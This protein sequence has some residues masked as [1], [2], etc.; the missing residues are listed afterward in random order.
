[1]CPH[2][3]F[4]QIKLGCTDQS[5]TVVFPWLMKAESIP[6]GN[7]YTS[8]CV[9]Q[10]ALLEIGREPCVCANF[11]L[12]VY[13]YL[14][15]RSR[16]EEKGGEKMRNPT[17]PHFLCQTNLRNSNAFIFSLICSIF[18]YDQPKNLF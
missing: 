10:M 1:M 4:Q 8:V 12:K 17:F 11:L 9:V 2:L 7:A 16:S 15:M 18:C 14:Y 6:F 5:H 13:E 3:C